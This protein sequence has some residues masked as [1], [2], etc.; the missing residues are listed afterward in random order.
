MVHKL[1]L[2]SY[3]L[4]NPDLSHAFV[5]TEVQ[6][7][8]DKGIIVQT[9]PEEGD[10]YSTVFLREKK[11]GKSYRMIINLKPIKKHILYPK[12]KTDTA[13]TFMQ[14][15]PEHGYMAALDLK[16]AYYSVKVHVD[17]Q[18]YLKFIWRDMHYK[19]VVLAMGL[20]SAPRLFIKFTKPMIA[21]L[22]A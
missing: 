1:N 13:Q 20:A 3:L 11:D 9:E 12:F 19:F 5:N 15:V 2:S 7:F 14:L 18:K 16:D 21:T 22:Q 10:F 17:F 4:R 8:L 6:K